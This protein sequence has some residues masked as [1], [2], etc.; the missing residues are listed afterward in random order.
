MGQFRGKVM[1]AYVLNSDSMQ[2][3]PKEMCGSN[4]SS[5]FTIT[6]QLGAQGTM[7]GLTGFEA[8]YQDEASQERSIQEFQG[9]CHS[10]LRLP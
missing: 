1:S 5:E 7:S 2:E 6:T 4:A 3:R 10:L 9:R 8:I